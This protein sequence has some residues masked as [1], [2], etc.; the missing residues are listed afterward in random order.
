MH[1]RDKN[2]FGSLDFIHSKIKECE[3]Y[4]SEMDLENI[5]DP[6][7]INFQIMPGDLTLRD[8]I[9]V[10]K[11]LK[12]EKSIHKS[13]GFHIRPFDH[14]Y[15]MIL[16]NMIQMSILDHHSDLI[17]DYHLYQWAKENGKE[18]KYLETVKQQMEIFHSIPLDLQIKSILQLGRMPHKAKQLLSL[19]LQDYAD[20]D[21]RQL[22]LRSKRQLGKLRHKLLYERNVDMAN[23]LQVELMNSSSFVSVG[24]AHLFGYKG[25]IRL[26]KHSGYQVLP[27]MIS[28]G[29]Y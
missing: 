23:K 22:Y 21:T 8:L 14:F 25:I 5:S 18:M 27:L 20:R 1:V 4:Y 19:M 16:A 24:A 15:P 26:L 29:S 2:A 10:K 7:F 28:E 13:F 3:F 9:P 12:L 17:L 6:Q 11:Y